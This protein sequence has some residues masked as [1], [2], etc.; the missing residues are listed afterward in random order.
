MRLALLLVACFGLASQ[1]LTTDREAK[2]GSAVVEQ[3]ERTYAPVADPFVQAYLNLIGGRIAA[4]MGT[5][6]KLSFTVLDNN[7]EKDALAVPGGHIFVSTGLILAAKSESELAGMLAQAM[8]PRP[9]RH[10][11]LKGTIPLVYIGG[12]NGNL[13][14]MLPAPAIEER[15]D[16]ELNADKA[17]FAAMLRAGFDPAAL[18]EFVAREQNADPRCPPDRA[19]RVAA[20]E[21]AIRNLPRATHFE[22]GDFARVQ[23]ALRPAAAPQTKPP[24]L[25]RP[26]Q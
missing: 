9:S 19:T 7:V 5:P 11:A 6:S 15:R 21:E 12:W 18:V 25:R 14:L 23:Q 26:Q 16:I 2:L 10:V 1:D 13:C 24:T 3:I 4:H 22:S 8:V 20:M 17:A